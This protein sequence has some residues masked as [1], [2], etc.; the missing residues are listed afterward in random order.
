ML[1]LTSVEGFGCWGGCTVTAGEARNRSSK[2]AVI[3][4]FEVDPRSEFTAWLDPAGIVPESRTLLD[5]SDA[6]A[7]GCDSAAAH[8]T[9][10]NSFSWRSIYKHLGNIQ[11]S[12]LEHSKQKVATTPVACYKLV[13]TPRCSMSMRT[14]HVLPETVNIW[15]VFKPRIK[16][17]KPQTSNTQM[18]LLQ[19]MQILSLDPIKACRIQATGYKDRI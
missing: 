7:V 2:P 17:P 12:S 3:S 9:F 14:D 19:Y 6:V 8:P 4:L 13:S 11:F 16:N 15:Q 10:Q 5:E 18:P 1:C